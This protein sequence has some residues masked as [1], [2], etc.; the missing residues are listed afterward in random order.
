M[1]REYI[2][3]GMETATYE[4]LPDDEGFYGAIP[5][6]RG[7]YASSETLEGCRKE[8]EE[9]LEG[10]I[11]VRIHRNLEIPEIDGLGIKVSSQSVA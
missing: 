11:L 8:L 9:V 1:I 6:C 4:L 7:V 10:W 5:S 3:R 2:Q